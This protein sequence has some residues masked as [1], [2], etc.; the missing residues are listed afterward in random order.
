MGLRAS[1]L[2]PVREMRLMPYRSAPILL[3]MKP[4]QEWLLPALEP[5]CPICRPRGSSRFAP[6][7][8][9]IRPPFSGRVFMLCSGIFMKENDACP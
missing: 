3:R 2:R 8:G 1:G 6:N 4:L 9:K 7:A 5:A